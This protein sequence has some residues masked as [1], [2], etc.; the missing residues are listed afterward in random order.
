[1]IYLEGFL[2]PPVLEYSLLRKWSTTQNLSTDSAQLPNMS[3]VID[4]GV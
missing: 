3:A 4:G 2:Q 1:M